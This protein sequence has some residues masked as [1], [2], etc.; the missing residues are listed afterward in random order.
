MG[1]TG[2]LYME[3]PKTVSLCVKL[4]SLI[5][6]SINWLCD[7]C[8]CLKQSG[9]PLWGLGLN[10]GNIMTLSLSGFWMWNSLICR[11]SKL[12]KTRVVL[13]KN[14]K[15]GISAHHSGKL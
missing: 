7:F 4:V 5:G 1:P 14:T 15:T 13:K 11:H 9:G 3:M 12:S 2:V 10:L 8:I 6:G